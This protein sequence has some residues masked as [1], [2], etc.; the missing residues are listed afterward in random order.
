MEFIFNFTTRVYYSRYENYKFGGQ[1]VE[2][3]R[4]PRYLRNFRDRPF[5]KN[6]R[7]FKY[8]DVIM[9][10]GAIWDIN[11]WGPLGPKEYS[12][13]IEKLCKFLLEI[14]EDSP[15]TQVIWM[16]TPPIRYSTKHTLIYLFF[17]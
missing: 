17:F 4:L 9:I 1:K 12:S 16:T 8:P 10:N 6:K 14:L 3:F 13:Y 2:N 11:R 5:F 15:K 7:K